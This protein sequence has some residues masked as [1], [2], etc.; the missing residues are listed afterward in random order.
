MPFWGSHFFL[1]GVIKL[2]FIHSPG[3]TL[4]MPP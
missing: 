1:I 3:T 2:V 4:Q